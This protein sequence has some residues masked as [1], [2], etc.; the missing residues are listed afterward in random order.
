MP[1]LPWHCY[2]IGSSGFYA[3]EA[4]ELIFLLAV[5]FCLSPLISPPLALLM[6]ILI[7]QFVGHPYL[8]LN[9]RA[10]HILL[11][12]AI[13]GL[14]FGMN[15][16]NALKA[17]REG[18]LLT[19]V[20]IAGTGILGLLLGKLLGIERQT[21]YLI[22]AGTA[23]CGGSAIAAVAP[24]IRAR[25]KPLSVALGTVFILNSLALFIFPA[26]GHALHLSQSQFGWWCAIAIHD[27][28][29]VVGAAGRYGAAALEIATTV[30]LVR[31][32]WIMPVALGSAFIFRYRGRIKVPWFIGLFVAGMLINTYIPGAAVVGR[33]VGPFA[34]ASLTLTLFLIGCGLTGNVLRSAG[35]K[36]LLQGLTLWAITA[37]VALWAVIAFEA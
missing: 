31:A 15:A 23:I 25:E 36:P 18:I 8:H 5:V 10:T 16:D 32:L 11:Q 24:V 35:A 28:S 3:G 12:I 29:S 9:G 33:Y 2:A 7:A 6:G 14:G 27:T 19:A 30:K 13:V 20:S 1:Q 17:G 4:R 37:G 26:V 22:T 21:A 34:K